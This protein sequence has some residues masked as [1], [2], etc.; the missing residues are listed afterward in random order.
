MPA[1]PLRNADHAA[2]D[3]RKL[4]DYALSPDNPAGRHEARVFAAALGFDRSNVHLLIHEIR[5]GVLVSPAEPGT[6]DEYGDRYR[7]DMPV[8]GPRGSATVR[9]AWIYRTGS[10]VRELVTLHVI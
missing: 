6:A 7:V 5:R 1:S 4:G 2:I 9:T 10:D 8:T 3:A